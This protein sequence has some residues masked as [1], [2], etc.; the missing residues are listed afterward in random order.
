MITGKFICYTEILHKPIIV[1]NILSS[2]IFRALGQLV[3]H[4]LIAY[5]SKYVKGVNAAGVRKIKRDILSMQQTLRG[6]AAS[7]EQG[8]LSRAAG[9]W[10]L[11]EQG[12]KVCRI[13]SDQRVI[14]ADAS[15]SQ[16]ML[17]ALKNINGTPPYTFEDYNTMLK[18]QCKSNTDELNTYL[19]DLHALSMDVEGWDLGED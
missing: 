17:E 9:F 19:I 12:P 14:M 18:L 10:D 16:K 11:Y 1:L 7:S 6:I 15:P 5:T 3:D 13:T 8:V 4:C 2:F